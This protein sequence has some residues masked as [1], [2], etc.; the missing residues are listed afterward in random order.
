MPIDPTIEKPIPFDEVPRLNWIP[1]R[2]RGRKLHYS[3]VNRWFR[4]GVRGVHLEAIRT[5]G[6]LCTSEQALARFFQQLATKDESEPVK[7]GDHRVSAATQREL[8]A[9]G[10]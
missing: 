6:T 7:G 8:E 10:L 2:R 1:R 4:R 3:T 5:G 9:H